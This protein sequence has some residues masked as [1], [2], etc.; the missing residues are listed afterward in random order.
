MKVLVS[1]KSDRADVRV[2]PSDEARAFAKSLDMKYIECSSKTGNGVE[3]IFRVVA[4]EL[5]ERRGGSG[6]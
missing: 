3:E 4:K 6:N 2:V 5:F 1:C